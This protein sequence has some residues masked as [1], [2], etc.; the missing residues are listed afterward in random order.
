MALVS[1]FLTYFYVSLMMN[2]FACRY[3]VSSCSMR[4]F[5]LE[6]KDLTLSTNGMMRESNSW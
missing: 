3:L 4:V 6:A 1:D 5:E 2:L